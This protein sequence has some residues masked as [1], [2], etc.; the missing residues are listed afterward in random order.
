M[1]EAIRTLDCI[2]NLRTEIVKAIKAARITGVGDNV[3][4]ARIEKAWPEENAF[5]C[6]NVPSVS[7]SDNRTSPRFYMATADVMIDI[8]ANAIDF[9]PAKPNPHGHKFERNEPPEIAD[10]LDDTAKAVIELLEPCQN[11]KGPFGGTVK[12]CVLKSLTNNLSE[13]EQAVGVTRIVFGVEFAICINH[14]APADE[15]RKA[16]TSLTMGQGEAN[17]QDF[18]T[19]V[20]P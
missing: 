5:V 13:R 2:K 7:F 20:R 12:R 8:L 17:R 14:T 6:V 11:Y 1:P 18:E 9:P 4:P 19:N 16:E 10:F 15:F 3:F